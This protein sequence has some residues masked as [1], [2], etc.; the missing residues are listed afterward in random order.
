MDTVDD[1]KSLLKFK[2]FGT[3]NLFFQ[4]TLNFIFSF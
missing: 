4:A 1:V 3:R 2:K